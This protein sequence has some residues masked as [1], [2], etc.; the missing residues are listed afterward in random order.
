[1]AGSPTTERSLSPPL[2]NSQPDSVRQRPFGLPSTTALVVANMIGA[3]VFTTSG[4][5]LADLGDRRWVLCAWL[6]GGGIALTGA[7]SYGRLAARFQESGGE[8][9]F[10]SRVIHPAV[11]FVAGWVSLLAGFTGAIAFAAT[12]F[13]VYALPADAHPPWLPQGA[14]AI[15]TIFLFAGLH[16]M[17]VRFGLRIQNLIVLTKLSLLVAFVTYAFMAL[18]SDGWSGLH[19]E[20]Q[21]RP[22]SIFAFAG[23]LV[24]ISLSYSG[25]NASVYVSGEVRDARRT[26]PKSLMLGTISVTL[27]Y[28]A[29]NT[30]FLYAPRPDEVVGREDIAAIAALALGGEGLAKAV[31]I[32][33][34]IALLTSISSMIVAGPRVYAQMARDGVFPPWLA[35]RGTDTPPT[36]SI[37]L[38]TLL[39]AAV[40]W[41]ATLEQLLSY[42]A[43]TLSLSA[44]ATVACLFVLQRRDVDR[45]KSLLEMAAPATYVTATL[46]LATLAAVNRPWQLAA[47]CLT[48]A[49]GLGLH[50]IFT[51]KKGA[52]QE[53]NL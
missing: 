21:G 9:V 36:K 26:V 5:A 6:V 50:A 20:N 32:A 38:Q 24:W 17:A 33:I 34:S 11:G 7:M 16:A 47:T 29:L 14:L 25:F 42:L 12:A 51:S 4:F 39:A 2:V 23:S 10:L 18:P 52:S 46:T 8:Y 41:M 28:L 49:S 3:G 22:F 43:F 31:R 1:L 45:K 27:L 30:I 15:S 13:E 48:V 35:D 40:V 19:V 44:A 53:R 37:V